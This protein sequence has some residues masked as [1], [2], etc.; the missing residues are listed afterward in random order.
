MIAAITAIRIKT[1]ANMRSHQRRGHPLP[2]PAVVFVFAAI[3]RTKSF[4]RSNPNLL[5]MIAPRRTAVRPPPIFRAAPHCRLSPIAAAH[6]FVA[7]PA[8][9]H[10]AADIGVQRE[11][12]NLEV[13]LAVALV[14]V[15]DAFATSA[16]DV[17]GRSLADRAR[18][19]LDTNALAASDL[20]VGKRDLRAAREMR[21][22]L[23]VDDRDAVDR[24]V[25]AGAN[26]DALAIAMHRAA[27]PGERRDVVIGGRGQIF[28]VDFD[29]HAGLAAIEATVFRV[30]AADL[31]A[32][33]EN[34]D[35]SERNRIAVETK[36]S[37]RICKA[38]GFDI[39]AF[40][41]LT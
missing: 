31:R 28:V 41:R 38:E 27:D 14:A 13:T 40:Q 26:V 9:T 25:N 12:A 19:D 20:V 36:T 7:T 29:L 24:A 32:H 37:C 5:A 4:S 3:V 15:A 23:G 2:L 11:A 17:V 6:V 1:M 8:L 34:G 35:V 39:N 22:A 30:D 33:R 21:R 16:G 10:T 18:I